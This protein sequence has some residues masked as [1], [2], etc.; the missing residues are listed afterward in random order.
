MH[1]TQEPLGR[2][3][4]LPHGSVI[5]VDGTQ[6]SAW[7]DTLVMLNSPDGSAAIA[8]IGRYHD[9]LVVEDGAWR[10]SA[11]VAVAVGEPLPEGVTPVSLAAL[12]AHP[13]A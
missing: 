2:T 8:W 12:D 1:T 9:Q 13:D 10:F 5:D 4:H 6:A 3:R 7:T 11:H